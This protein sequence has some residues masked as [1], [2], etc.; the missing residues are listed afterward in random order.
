MAP[1]TRL[2]R[3]ILPDGI[4]PPP[5]T[6]IMQFCR[7]LAESGATFA[8][9]F[10][11]KSETFHGGV[12]TPVPLNGARVP[13]TMGG[14]AAADWRALPEAPLAIEEPFGPDYDSAVAAHTRLGQAKKA[15]SVLNKP[16]EMAMR[17]R[18]QYKEAITATGTEDR[19]AWESRLKG[20]EAERDGCLDAATAIIMA[21]DKADVSDRTRETVQ[22][23]S[24]EGRF[25]FEDKERFG[26]Y[27]L[28]LQRA[29]QA[30]FAD[31]NKLLQRIKAIK[32]GVK[33]SQV[34]SAPAVKEGEA[35]NEKAAD[36]SA[37]AVKEGEEAKEK[38]PAEA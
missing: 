7:D 9:T 13:D 6:D 12:T 22:A 34:V 38:A 24:E 31:Q 18:V 5:G 25:R 8:E 35:A 20:A 21:M 23:V 27:M 19:T 3:G 26:D 17:L 16:V 11:R 14:E 30:I 33:T 28:V 32:K 1:P 10:D 15:I 4:S 36:A 2:P 37:P 29:N